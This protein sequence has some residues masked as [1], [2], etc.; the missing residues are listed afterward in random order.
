MPRLA[1]YTYVSAV[2]LD[3]V[4]DDCE[5]DTRAATGPVPRLVSSIEAVEDMGQILG[6]NASAG[7]LCGDQEVRTVGDTE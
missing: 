2:R 7:V 4:L 6:G 5:A 3:R 1:F